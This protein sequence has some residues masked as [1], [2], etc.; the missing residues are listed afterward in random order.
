MSGSVDWSFALT[1][2]VPNAIFVQSA[3]QFW[4][5]TTEAA[6]KRVFFVSLWYLPVVLGLMMI[7]KNAAS[8]LGIK[9]DEEDDAERIEARTDGKLA[10]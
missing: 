4:R 8:W 9:Q 2:A 6:A 1:S 7:H 3:W 10:L 5:H